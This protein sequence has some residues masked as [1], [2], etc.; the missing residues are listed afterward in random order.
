MLGLGGWIPK[1][2]AP[3]A[4][5]KHSGVH[6]FTLNPSPK[7]PVYP[8]L[9]ANPDLEGSA[10]VDK[11]TMTGTLPFMQH[12]PGA[13]SLGGLPSL[14]ILGNRSLFYSM[15]RR[16]SSARDSDSASTIGRR[17]LSSSTALLWAALVAAASLLLLFFSSSSK[18]FLLLSSSSANSLL[19][20]FFSFFC[21]F[22]RRRRLELLSDDDDDCPL[23]GPC[24]S[25]D[26]LVLVVFKV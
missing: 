7:N 25:L 16:A 19:L 1:L 17:A 10:T 22:R 21:L 2:P 6:P 23:R 13:S 14:L 11:V 3:T 18:I 8:I 4:L 24:R 20:L 26:A 15:C 12:T 5:F 9:E